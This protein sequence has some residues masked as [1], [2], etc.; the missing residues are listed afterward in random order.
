MNRLILSPSEHGTQWFPGLP[1]SNINIKE[2]CHV[3]LSLLFLGTQFL[4]TFH[5]CAFHPLSLRH[6]AWPSPS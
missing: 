6:Q 2:A 5:I 3:F 1:G 4:Q